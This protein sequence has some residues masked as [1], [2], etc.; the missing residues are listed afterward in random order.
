M[1]Y[2]NIKFTSQFVCIFGVRL[3]PK[4]QT[5]VN[6]QR[7]FKHCKIMHNCEKVWT[8]EYV[9][10]RKTLKFIREKGTDFC[11]LPRTLKKVSC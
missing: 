3:I 10:R 4:V 5:I 6:L 9:L 11:F 1:N 2:Y 8:S 7:K